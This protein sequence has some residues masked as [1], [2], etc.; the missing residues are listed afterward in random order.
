M[1]I[2][3]EKQDNNMVK[4]HF[5]GEGVTIINMLRH[6]L[7]ENKDIISAG[8]KE[9]HPLIDEISLVVRAKK[10]PIKIVRQ[11]LKELGEEWTKLEIV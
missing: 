8:Y 3:I 5:K 4:I 9:E 7:F 10:D 11:A 2:S 1:K 6:K